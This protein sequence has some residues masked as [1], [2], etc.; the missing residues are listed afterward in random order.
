M[1]RHSSADLVLGQPL[2]VDCFDYEAAVLWNAHV[3]PLWSRT[4]SEAR[5][6][7]AADLGL[8][9]GQARSRVTL[10]YAKVVEF[11]ARGLVHIHAV[12]RLD[13]RPDSSKAD[14]LVVGDEIL[15]RA[16]VRAAESA[17]LRVH[18]PGKEMRLEWGQQIDAESLTGDD[19]RRV[20]AYIAKYATKSIGSG[21]A[22]DQRL[23]RHAQI[24]DLAVNEHTRRLVATCWRLGAHPQFASIRL[25]QW[26]HCLGY[27][28]HWLTKSRHY[29]TTFGSLR[30]SRQ[31]HMRASDSER[32]R[33]DDAI[34]IGTWAYAGRGYFADNGTSDG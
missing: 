25:R 10:S 7:I 6:N 19:P 1:V 2:C 8:T 14:A 23:R 18:L 22:L 11:Q 12:I 31:D 5:R 32:L 4:I 34:Q 33:A 28:G 26:A 16:L 17:T 21:G 9:I 29:S 24:A 15:M 13:E 3:G 30:A 27:R 20:A